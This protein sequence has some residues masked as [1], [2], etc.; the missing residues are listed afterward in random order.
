[1]YEYSVTLIQIVDGDTLKLDVDVGFHLHLQATF[2][3]AR[4]NAP[5]MYSFEGVAAKAFVVARLS[6]ATAMKIFSERS[7][8]YGRWLCE[9]YF[10]T[11]NSKS[12]WIN[13]NSL[14]L[15]SGHALPY[16]HR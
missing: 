15:S 1:M 8:K 12:Q 3:L 10:Q 11:K 13:L 14:M 6:E 16:R 4:I 5:E 9:F 2:R 7:E